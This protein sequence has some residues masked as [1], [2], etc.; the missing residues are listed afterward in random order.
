MPKLITKRT[1]LTIFEE[2][3]YRHK[4]DKIILNFF[5]LET[6]NQLNENN[7]A[8][9]DVVIKF[10]FMLNTESLLNI[11]VKDTK[12][13]FN[14]SKTF[15]INF[16]YREVEKYHVLLIPCYWEV[17]IPY[18]YKNKKSKNQIYLLANLFYCEKESKIKLILKKLN[19]FSPKEIEDIL[20]KIRKNI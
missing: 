1:F 19:L 17:Y 8:S 10:V 9:E 7:I 13:I 5:G 15:Y 18:C 20:L 6:S 11:V 3:E 4:L 2:E 16:S 12:K 14:H